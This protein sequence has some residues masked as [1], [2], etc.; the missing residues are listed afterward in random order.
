M[1]GTEMS[2]GQGR[3]WLLIIAKIGCMNG[4]RA[5]TG[6]PYMFMLIAPI[7]FMLVGSTIFQPLTPSLLRFLW[8]G[9]C[10]LGVSGPHFVKGCLDILFPKAGKAPS[11][12]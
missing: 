9:F 4:D 11:F 5:T 7:C 6:R 2:P 1:T 10:G 8:K 12:V 3:V